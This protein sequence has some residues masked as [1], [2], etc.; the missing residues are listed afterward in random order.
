MVAGE[1]IDHE[2]FTHY[3]QII[4]NTED[5]YA[6]NSLRINDYILTPA[7]FPNV[8]RK[9]SVLKKTILE[10]PLSEFQKVDGGL[11]CLSLRF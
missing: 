4:V 3:N 8:L 7:G 9:L 2:I 11:S 6:A 10:L 1:F 5:E